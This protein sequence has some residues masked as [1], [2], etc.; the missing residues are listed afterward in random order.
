MRNIFIVVFI[1]LFASCKD[2]TKFVINGQINNAAPGKQ[3]V[4]LLTQTPNGEIM[5]L[6]SAVLGENK[7]FKLQ[8]IATE[9]TFYQIAYNN[10]N[11]MLIAQNGDEIDF[12]LDDNK[13]NTYTVTGC[14]EADK[15][16]AFNNIIAAYTNKSAAIEQKYSVM[17]EQNPTQKNNIIQQYQNQASLNLQPFLAKTYQFIQI[18]AQSL[19]AFYAANTLHSLD[20]N[21]DYESKII[22]YAQ[23]IKT[24]F[25]NTQVQNF[26]TQMDA[27][28]SVSVGKMA[29]DIISETPEGKTI[30]LSSLKGK[31]VLLDFWASWCGPCRQEN[32]F[33]VAAFN[34]FK[35]K[36]FT[37][38]SF[39]LDDDK[40]NWI[41]AIEEDKLS[42]AH[43]ADFKGFDSPFAL[44]YNVSAIPHSLLLNPEGKIIAKNLRGNALEIFLESEIK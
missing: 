13:P 3:M 19:T 10:H 2:K 25:N 5:V 34:K 33:V 28:A 9:A 39:S 37:I 6:D 4:R 17:L 15:I 16:V 36:N 29:P 38:F 21:G 8:A 14:P 27:I 40:T 20:E 41:K 22:A 24:K 11:Y 44:L 43:A 23:S 12:N 32:P 7:D 42:W 18:N 31:Y 30:Q 35:N 1:F 26:I